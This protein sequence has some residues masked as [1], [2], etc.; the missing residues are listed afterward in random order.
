M[1]ARAARARA[2]AAHRCRQQLGCAG[3]AHFGDE[4]AVAFG[5]RPAHRRGAER[6]QRP[7]LA[8]VRDDRAEEELLLILAHELVPLARDDDG[9]LAEAPRVALRR[10]RAD[11][12]EADEARVL[13]GE[14]A[15]D[16]AAAA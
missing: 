9:V 8:S 7:V 5:H 2:L 11:D 13:P 14:G 10:V 3:A 12:A 1:R 6:R 4:R 15:V 16:H